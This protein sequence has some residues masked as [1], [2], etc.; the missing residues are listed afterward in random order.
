MLKNK[1][2]TDEKKIDELLSRAVENIYPDRETLRKKLLSGERLRLYCGFD[3]TGE[4]LHIGHGIQIK[5]L[6]EFRRL[7]HEVIFL[8]GDFTAMIGDPTDKLSARQPITPAQV[9]KNLKGWKGQIKNIID[10]NKI[11]FKFNSKW[12]SKL[13]FADIIKLSSEFSVQQ[14]MERD[15]FQERVKKEKPVFTNEFMY[16]LMQAY[17]SVVMDV[18]L[19]I[20][21]NDQTFNM[22][23][24]RTLMRKMKNKE[25]F[26]LTTKLLSDP[27]G[28]KMGKTEGN[29]IALTDSPEDMFGKV[30]SWTDGMI[31]PALEI[32]TD[33]PMEMVRDVEA[34]LKDGSLNPRDAKLDLAYEVVKIYLGDKAAEAG[35][36]N[37]K[38]VVQ[39][40]EKPAEIP[41]I[42]LEQD[43]IGV[44]D[45][46]VKAGLAV[47][48]GEVRR[49]IAEKGLKIDDNLVN[50]VDLK[51]KI[52]NE[53]LLLQRGKRQFVKVK[54]T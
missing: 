49:L 31:V 8:F 28:K 2:S 45:L 4:A 27:E 6:E 43:E 1:V 41:V 36:D 50:S 38:R 15:M 7:G 40:K 32:V 25:K 9:K 39:D 21:G 44:L 54:K 48:N 34:K 24:G 46:F 19:E 26:V 35:R 11:E 3:P 52:S 47:S 13:N 29:M 53:V 42:K 20:G 18:D 22:L 37:F 14:M 51:V 30:M 5:K 12:L 16:P 23:A 33:V 10:V 17:D